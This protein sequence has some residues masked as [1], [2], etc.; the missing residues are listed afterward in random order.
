MAIIEALSKISVPKVSRRSLNRLLGNRTASDLEYSLVN[1]PTK[2]VNIIKEA[3]DHLSCPEISDE[4]NLGN[5]ALAI[6]RPKAVESRIDI[7]HEDNAAKFLIEQLGPELA[8]FFAFPFVFNKQLVEAFWEPNYTHVPSIKYHQFPNAWEEFKYIMTRGAST[9]VLVHSPDGDAVP[10]IRKKVGS[11]RN[12][13]HGSIRAEMTLKEP[14]GYIANNLI[15][16][17]D[18][19]ENVKKELNI[20]VSE[21]SKMTKF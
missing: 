18:S 16:S 9:V 19:S 20:I 7:Y 2:K 5:V 6:V 13:E 4:I 11:W 10:K 21:L 8:V 14:N 1:F 12:P 3:L 17:S 15:H